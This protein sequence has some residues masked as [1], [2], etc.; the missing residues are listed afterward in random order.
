M[1]CLKRHCLFGV[2]ALLLRKTITIIH[3][4]LSWVIYMKS[5]GQ[6]LAWPWFLL[7]MEDLFLSQVAH[8]LLVNIYWIIVKKRK[9]P[10]FSLWSP[11]AVEEAPSRKSTY[12]IISL[13]PGNR[14]RWARLVQ[15]SIQHYLQT[16]LPGNQGQHTEKHNEKYC[17][18]IYNFLFIAW[19]LGRREKCNV[20]LGYFPLLKKP[21]RRCRK[22][23]DVSVCYLLTS[24]FELW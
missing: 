13:I 3:Y 20:R 6:G 15:L 21:G 14:L 19:A 2:T 8:N 23:T 7:K 22:V 1:P 12:V 24:I 17:D 11:D 5:T 16:S 10:V 18:I 4:P 9:L